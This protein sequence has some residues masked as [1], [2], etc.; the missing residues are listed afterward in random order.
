M[1]IETKNGRISLFL[2]CI[3]GNLMTEFYRC[4]EVP[5]I[6]IALSHLGCGRAKAP[7]QHFFLDSKFPEGL[8]LTFATDNLAASYT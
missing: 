1:A 2:T 3:E 5:T 6:L 8:Q 4:L 7:R